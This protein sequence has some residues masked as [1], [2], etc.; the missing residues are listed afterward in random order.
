MDGG[1]V[2]RRP[3]PVRCGLSARSSSG[4]LSIKHYSAAGEG[5][6]AVRGTGRDSPTAPASTVES[7]DNQS[8]TRDFLATRGAKI[9]RNRWIFPSTAATS[10]ART[11]PGRGRHAGRGQCRVLHPAGTGNLSWV[12]EGVLEALA[13]ALQLDEAEQAHLFDLARAASTSRKPQ[14]RRPAT[15]PGYALYSE[16][17]ASPVRPANHA[18]SSSWTTVPTGSTRT[19]SAPRM[20][21]WRSCGPRPAVTP[22]TVA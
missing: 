11:A 14:R 22:S 3:A 8:E 18:R 16:M 6:P 2:P 19:G 15:Q 9:T 10:G 4:A 12:S 5:V 20:T 21:R 13:R 7:M 1:G 17:Y